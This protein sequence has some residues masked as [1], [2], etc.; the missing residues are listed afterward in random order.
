MNLQSERNFTCPCCGG[1]SFR[2]SPGSYEICKV[3][4]WED[5]PVQL[6]DSGFV[7][8]ANK[9]SL[10]E[11]QRD[12]VAAGVG[13]SCSEKSVRPPIKNESQDSRWRRATAED[14]LK[15]KS[16]VDL[17]QEERSSIESWYYWLCRN[18]TS[19]CRQTSVSL[20]YTAAAERQ[21]R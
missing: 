10:L 13:E 9:S 11:C 5:D 20:R 6:L 12:F 15:A 17:S 14:L 8:G 7:G 19:R 18:L 4:S 2:A 21:N 3:C 1:F 16:P